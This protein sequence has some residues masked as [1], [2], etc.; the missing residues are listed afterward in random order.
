M[1]R[2]K[3]LAILAATVL[4]L[5][6]CSGSSTTPTA[7]ATTQQPSVVAAIALTPSAATAASPSPAVASLA[8]AYSEIADKGNAALVQCNKDR[9][10]AIGSLTKAKAAA[11]ECLNTY[12]GY[13]TDLKA[14]N[15]GPVQ[16][17]A[18]KVIADMDNIDS[19]M[20]LMINAP[21]ATS[22]RSAYDQ[23]DPMGA[24]LLV[25]ANAMRAAL[26]LPPTQS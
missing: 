19:L 8:S 13:V 2:T 18:D 15:W 7:S 5:G 23:L 24:T 14:I 3:G 10:A 25:D 22:F 26:G 9:A 6:A 20:V 12:I 21:D 16:P 11:Q 17:Q 1:A 4:I